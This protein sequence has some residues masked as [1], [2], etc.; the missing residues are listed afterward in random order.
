[1]VGNS[2]RL[3][4]MRCTRTPHVSHRTFGLAA[5]FG[6]LRLTASQTMTKSRGQQ[7]LRRSRVTVSAFQSRGLDLGE[8]HAWLSSLPIPQ[9]TYDESGA[10]AQGRSPLGLRSPAIYASGE[11]QARERGDDIEGSARQSPKRRDSSRGASSEGKG[12][13]KRL[14]S[15]GSTSGA[16]MSSRIQCTDRQ[17]S[18][19]KASIHTCSP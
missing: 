19:E 8:L 6:G 3:R 2:D 17:H 5:P 9:P 12:L 1:M 11:L 10:I 7:Q 15:P 4:L 13:Q 14:P 18:A 16:D